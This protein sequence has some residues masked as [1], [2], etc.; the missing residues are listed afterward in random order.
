MISVILSGGAGSRLWPVSR[1]THP[2][3]F[4]KLADGLSLIQKA[5][6]RGSSLPDVKEL[7]VITNQ[8]L[9]FETREEF[10]SLNIRSE[11]SFILEP[12]GRNTAAAIAAASLDIQN[13]YGPD[14]PIL[15]LAADHLIDSTDEFNMAIASALNMAQEGFLV[16]FGI[17]PTSPETGYGYIE[18]E[19]SLVKR[20][21][22]KPTAEK[23][24][25]Y[26]TSGNFYWNS[27]IFCFTAG[28]VLEEFTRYS[29]KVLESTRECIN[30]SR[31]KDIIKP[32][33]LIL[34]P[35]TFTKVPSI[36]ID[37][38]VMEKSEKLAVIP[39]NFGW[40]DVG[41]WLSLA[42]MSNID[43]DGNHIL[44]PGNA[45]VHDT[46]NC[47]IYNCKRLIA[48]L[49]LDN[50]IIVDTPDAT[51]VAKADKAQ[52][53]KTVYNTLMKT[54]HESYK[55]HRTVYRP[56]GAFTVL[57]TSNNFKI[58]RLKINPGGIISLQLHKHRSEHWIVVDGTAQVT[59]DTK[60]FTLNANE[61]T[62][63]SAGKVHRV[64]NPATNDLVIIEIQYGDYLG[65]DDIE[66]FE[67][68][69]G[70]CV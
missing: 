13:R 55:T 44:I 35:N 4:I 43:A 52:E 20:F 50:I 68:V 30:K 59:C 47:Y 9:Y 61:S 36:S 6:L 34:E 23:A 40:S 69:Y 25:E 60:T 42:S 14:E 19:G 37:Y 12:F 5:M 49:G 10:D 17:H 28:T 45:T 21:I 27:G 15:V 33:S 16:T 8:N 24:L 65:E 66:R 41:S 67:D 64:Y 26:V 58:K 63:I 51:L 46:S 29:P 54:G 48:T 2:K 22:E 3:P 53:V 56:W 18:A 62:Y 70:R 32:N 7:M 57:E 11:L 39:S 38:A 31:E 1:E